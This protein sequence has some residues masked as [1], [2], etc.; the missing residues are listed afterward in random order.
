MAM[1]VAVRLTDV[2]YIKFQVYI[3]YLIRTAGSGV[4]CQGSVILRGLR[5]QGTND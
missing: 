5:G 2:D 4:R 1:L 3:I